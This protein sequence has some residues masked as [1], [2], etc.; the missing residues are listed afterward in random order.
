MTSKGNYDEKRTV[1]IL[2]TG[3]NGKVFELAVIQSAKI[4]RV[5]VDPVF[6]DVSIAPRFR[7]RK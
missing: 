5:E 2:V 7:L 1:K 3:D 6:V 4:T